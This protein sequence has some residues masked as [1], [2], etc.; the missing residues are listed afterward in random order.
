MDGYVFDSYVKRRSVICGQC[1]LA[2]NGLTTQNPTHLDVWTSIKEIDGVD[3]A[4]IRYIFND[5]IDHVYEVHPMM[6]NSNLLLPTRERAIVEYV[7]CERWRDEGTLIE[8]LK[9]YL[10]NFNDLPHL[11][12][13]ADFFGL[14]KIELDFWINEAITDE[15]I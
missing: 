3:A 9:T 8:A 5:K 11:Y 14:N 2:R 1:A 6:G 10:W 13:V 12:E 4:I 7:L 15:E